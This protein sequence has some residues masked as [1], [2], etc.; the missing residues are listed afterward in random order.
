[1]S[2]REE[3]EKRVLETIEDAVGSKEIDFEEDE[4]EMIHSIFELGETTV[5]EVMIPRVDMVCVEV[6]SELEYLRALAK[7]KGHSRFPVYREDIDNILGIATVKDLL[8]VNDLSE[9]SLEA[10]IRP[11]FFIPENKK[12]DELLREM[13]K[14]KLHM[15][16]VLDEY[17]GT[18]GLVTLEDI[19]EE[20]V[21]EIEDESDTL[22]PP[23]LKLDNGSYSVDAA[24]SLKDLN[25]VIGSRLPE[26]EF[27]TVG[28]MIYD[29]VGSL[30]EEGYQVERHGLRF[31]V[32]RV[33]GQRIEIVRVAFK[34]EEVSP[35]EET[36]TEVS[37]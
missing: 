19:L 31:I 13:R 37:S 25:E 7:D 10:L 20:I 21:G 23:I 33:E 3:T 14:K 15:A 8:F 9:T 5:K 18:S 2:T 30:P 28:G 12:I 11:T 36:S 35:D 27:E 22:P 26:E 17:G 4:K 34:R 6:N 16:I 29:L 24:V 32:E 1:M